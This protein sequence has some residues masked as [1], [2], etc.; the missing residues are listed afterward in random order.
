MRKDRD[1]ES[2]LRRGK[3]KTKRG[4]VRH[5][6]KDSL[7]KIRFQGPRGVDVY[8]NNKG[9]VSNQTSLE[10]KGGKKPGRT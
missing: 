9:G 4:R 8:S 2:R 1:L 7:S 6:L 10:I 5:L 3:E